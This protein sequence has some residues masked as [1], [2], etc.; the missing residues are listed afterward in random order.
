MRRFKTSIIGS[1]VDAG[2]DDRFT[3]WC[4]TMSNFTRL[5]LYLITEYKT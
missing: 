5:T 2:R 3:L 1:I 4:L